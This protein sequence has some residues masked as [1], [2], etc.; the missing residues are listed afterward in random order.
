MSVGLDNSLKRETIDYNTV[1]ID[2]FWLISA[3]QGWGE[4]WEGHGGIL[5]MEAVVTTNNS[6]IVP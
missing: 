6:E 2:W 4:L 1:C 3:W 5:Q